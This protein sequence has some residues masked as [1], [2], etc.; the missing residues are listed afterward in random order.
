MQK[1]YSITGDK[2]HEKNH[3]NQSDTYFFGAAF[4]TAMT[5]ADI[6]ADNEDYT[7]E[8]E[9]VETVSVPETSVIPETTTMQAVESTALKKSE[10]TT[11]KK[12]KK[13]EHTT[14]IKETE[15]ATVYV[16]EPTRAHV[17]KATKAEEKWIQFE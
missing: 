13:K 15:P 7:L 12:K 17:P 11:V 10:E 5:R 14:S 9:S 3:H 1:G 8:L 2:K 6:A 16:P 4:I